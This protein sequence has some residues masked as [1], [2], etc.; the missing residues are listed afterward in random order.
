MVTFFKANKNIAPSCGE[1]IRSSKM[2]YRKRLAK[3][4]HMHEILISKGEQK[5]TKTYQNNQTKWVI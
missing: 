1:C 4:Q 3:L 2:K 5:R